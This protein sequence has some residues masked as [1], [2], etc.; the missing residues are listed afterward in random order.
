MKLDS[1]TWLGTLCAHTLPC[2]RKHFSSRLLSGLHASHVIYWTGH[3][4]QLPNG[5]HTLALHS[6]LHLGF[7]KFL[8]LEINRN[9]RH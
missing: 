7:G 3:V 5:P 4:S 1:S 8:F 9:W 2:I 6:A